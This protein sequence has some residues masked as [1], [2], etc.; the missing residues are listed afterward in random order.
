MGFILLKRM[1]MYHRIT[2]LSG[3]QTCFQRMYKLKV[4]ILKRY[5]NSSFFARIEI[6]G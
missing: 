3:F 5:I 6:A 1:Q 4:L 2:D